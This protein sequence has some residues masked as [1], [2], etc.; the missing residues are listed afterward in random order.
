MHV[1]SHKNILRSQD[2]GSGLSVL[3]QTGMSRVLPCASPLGVPS[4]HRARPRLCRCLQA[5]NEA[6]PA[7]QYFGEEYCWTVVV[8]LVLFH[9]WTLLVLLQ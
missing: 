1:L 6:E 2:L 4:S 5:R 9:V 8:I 7:D 3:G